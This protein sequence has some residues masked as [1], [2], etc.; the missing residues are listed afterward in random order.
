MFKLLYQELP[1]VKSRYDLL[2]YGEPAVTKVEEREGEVKEE[3]KCMNARPDCIPISG[4]CSR[5][6]PLERRHHVNRY[7]F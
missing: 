4:G 3:A 6:N 2:A 1:K 7:Y 5:Q